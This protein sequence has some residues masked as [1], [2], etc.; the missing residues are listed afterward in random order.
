MGQRKKSLI[1]HEELN[2]W[3]LHSDALPSSHRDCMVIKTYYKVLMTH[4]PHTVRISNVMFV[5]RIR[6]MTSFEESNLRPSD[7]MLR[8]Y[9]H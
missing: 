8:M 3:I 6:E 1:P 4:V 2:L 7:S 9:Y 5:N